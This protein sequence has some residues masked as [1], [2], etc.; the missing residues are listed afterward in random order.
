MACLTK[1]TPSAWFGCLLVAVAM[2]AGCDSGPPMGDVTGTV[3]VNGAPAK[4]GAVSFFPV[5]GKAGT[6][7]AVIEDGKYSARVPVGK[8][9]VEIRVPKI[10]GYKKLY[11]TPNSPTQPI[12]EEVL[13]A[14]YNEQ[15][16]IELEVQ[17]GKNEKNYDLK[18]P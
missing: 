3:T 1:T 14:K 8:A 7:G 9:R 10:V 18:T 13:P 11:A 6:A 5:D 12:M 4:T 2:V 15:S 16:E 17:R